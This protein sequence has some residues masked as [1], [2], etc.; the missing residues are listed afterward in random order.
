MSRLSDFCA[1]L[2]T[3][4]LYALTAYHATGS[5]TRLELSAFG[6]PAMSVW[7]VTLQ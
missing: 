5:L 7:F 4:L 3:D 1:I 6:R 2:E